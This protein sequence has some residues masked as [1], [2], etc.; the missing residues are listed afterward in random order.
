MV[1]TAQH[2]NF[3]SPQ[4]AENGDP[5]VLKSGW[6]GNCG[7]FPQKPRSR[8]F[9]EIH[10][11]DPISVIR[12]GFLVEMRMAQVDMLGRGD[13]LIIINLREKC[14]MKQRKACCKASEQ[15]FPEVLKCCA[16]PLLKQPDLRWAKSPTAN[17]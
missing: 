11:G 8:E 7:E 12:G 9:R 5:K 16:K 3:I 6:P 17:R 4:N 15:T 10:F 1:S 2:I 13:A 14:L